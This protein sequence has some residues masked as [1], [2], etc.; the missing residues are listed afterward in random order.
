MCIVLYFDAEL[1]LMYIGSWTVLKWW[2][3]LDS[4]DDIHSVE[5]KITVFFHRV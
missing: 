2:L 5:G 4:T 1:Y 3:S